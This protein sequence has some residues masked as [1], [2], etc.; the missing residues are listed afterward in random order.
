MK[1]EL[2]VE[3]LSGYRTEVAAGQHRISS[4]MLST[5]SVNTS[6]SRRSEKAVRPKSGVTEPRWGEMFAVTPLMGVTAVKY[7][8]EYE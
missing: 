1:K 3:A 6:M 7:W 8:L 2:V 5:G 4:K